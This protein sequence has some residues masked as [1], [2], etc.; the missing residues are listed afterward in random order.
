MNESICTKCGAP[1]QN[2]A[3]YCT[4][5]GAKVNQPVKIEV[6]E[7]TLAKR[8]KD[9]AKIA[10]QSE[11]AKARETKAQQKKAVHE[12]YCANNK[13][14]IITLSASITATILVV[15]IVLMCVRAPFGASRDGYDISLN[16]D[17]SVTIDGYNGREDHVIIPEYVWYLGKQ[18]KVTEI[19][20]YAFSGCT[21]KSVKMH[22]GIK[23]IGVGAFSSCPYLTNV[24]LSDRLTSLNDQAFAYC[25]SLIKLV[26]PQGVNIINTAVF[27]DCSSLVEIY[28]PES[29]T[30]IS[31][32]AFDGCAGLT[33][34]Y[35]AGSAEQ[36]NNVQI[37]TSN[38]QCLAFAIVIYDVN[39]N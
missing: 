2:N 8:A 20:D 22:N 12:E 7:K 31:N 11:K 24:V 38:N 37:S 18:R 16:N 30:F 26:I 14:K 32:A 3:F 28:L 36:W 29:I 17:G 4:K 27:A 19:G 25:S 21:V 33:Y 6:S 15:G 34:I 5:C 35:Y 13:K 10:E 23:R 39:Y 9:E 1:L